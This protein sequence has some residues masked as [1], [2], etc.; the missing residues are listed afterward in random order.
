M[1][2]CIDVQRKMK[3]E[4]ND[5]DNDSN[6]KNNF[7]IAGDLSIMPQNAKKWKSKFSMTVISVFL[8]VVGLI[9][10]VSVIYFMFRKKVTFNLGYSAS[11]ANINLTD[12]EQNYLKIFD[13]NI[14]PVLSGN[15]VDMNDF[16]VVHRIEFAKAF[17]S[18]NE[19]MDFVDDIM[20]MALLYKDKSGKKVCLK[21][22]SDIIF[23][24]DQHFFERHL[25]LYT[26]LAKLFVG[27]FYGFEKINER[28]VPQ[29]S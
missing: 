1:S 14:L 19:D 3:S 24:A 20:K 4:N 9:V 11:A 21:H 17:L 2:T 25:N 6:N 16:T 10:G 12:E 15:V 22:P 5:N 28:I 23:D 27:N 18:K 26:N 8:V 7:N 13:E 29:Y